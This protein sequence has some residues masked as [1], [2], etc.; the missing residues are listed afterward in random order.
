MEAATANEILRFV[1]SLTIFVRFPLQLQMDQLPS[2]NGAGYV[3]RRIL[4]RAVRYYYS[5]LNIQQPLMHELMEVLADDFKHVFPELD[6]QRVFIKKL[7]LKEE[8]SFLRTLGNGLKRLD[9]IEIKDGILDGETAFE[10]YDTYGFPFDLTQLVL[11]EKGI[12]ADEAGFEA[13][14]QA[15]KNRGKADAKKEVGDWT[16]LTDDQDVEFVGYDDLETTSRVVKY[17]T[18]K[19]KKKKEYQIVLDTTPFYPEGGGQV[20]DKGFLVFDEERISVLDTKKENDLIIHVVKKLPKKVDVTVKAVVNAKKRRATENVH[21]ATHLLHAAL[22][23]VLGTHVAQK[24]SLVEDN[25]LRFDFSHFE[26]VTDEQLA[27][28]ETIVNQKIRENI[29]LEEARSISIEESKGKRCND[30]VW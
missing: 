25:K 11:S 12:K 29:S 5:F 4:R 8:E 13:A 30:V 22:R 14:L 16:V 7:I 24:G 6:A 15:Q 10:L 18:V 27:E 3:I 2:N 21:S 23:N 17:R 9:G 26:K 19:A 20:G 28:I 1:S